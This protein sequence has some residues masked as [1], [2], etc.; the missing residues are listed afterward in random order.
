MNIY[1]SL[2][3]KNEE[4]RIRSCLD[5]LSFAK[6]IILV[7]N[8]SSDRTV[9]IAKTFKNVKVVSVDIK[10]PHSVAEQRNISLKHMPKDCWVY[11]S[12]ADEIITNSL[13]KE[14]S[15]AIEQNTYQAFQ[16]PRK[17]IFLGRELL[18]GGWYPDFQVRL[19]KINSLIKWV[20]APLDLPEYIYEDKYGY[21]LDSNYGAHDKPL[22]RNGS[23]V[24][25][26]I[27]PYLHFNHRSL[28]S[29]LSKTPRFL[30]S[31][32][33]HLSQYSRIEEPTGMRIVSSPIIYFI[34]SYFLKRG[35]LDGKVGLIEAVYM[36]FS[37]FIYESMKWE[38]VNRKKI[39]SV[40]EKNKSQR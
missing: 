31:E 5:S 27:N 11:F 33:R 36:S 29:M 25:K 9:K 4:A 32:L 15:K 35:F 14:I 28:E 39:E 3:T 12:D 7:D 37:Q 26:L 16:V 23:K 21:L 2:I 1:V 8:S 40:Y 22:L 24:G 19:I 34:K 18:Y 10:L 13:K 20:N 38:Y 30:Q 17:N 6:E